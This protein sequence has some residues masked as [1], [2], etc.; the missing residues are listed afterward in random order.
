MK[1]TNFLVIAIMFAQVNLFAQTKK[2]TLSFT[3]GEFKVGWG[4]STFG[5]GL[6]EQY[7]AGNFSTSGGFLASIAAYHKF[8]KI[9]HV[10][11]GLKFKSLGA[12]PSRGDNN[13]EMF[14]NYWGAALSTKYY[15]FDKTAR[16]GLFVQGD[17]FFVTQFTQK[18]RN[19]ATNDYAHQFAIGNGLA[20]SSGYD[21]EVGKTKMVV[22]VEYQIDSRT[23]EVQGIGKKTFGSS[24]LGVMVGVKF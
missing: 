11:F 22:G 9:N 13:Q 3:V 19:K 12:T 1:N 8:K 20:F 18:Y 15:P 2:D 21:F 24:N 6:K 10:T 4:N 5:N 7:E 23:G 16:K 14:F 17:I